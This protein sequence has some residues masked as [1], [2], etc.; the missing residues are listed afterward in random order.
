MC[1]HD[2]P[3]RLQLALQVGCAVPI[4]DHGI[5]RRSTCERWRDGPIQ[6]LENVA[7]RRFVLTKLLGPTRRTGLEE[8][9]AGSGTGGQHQPCGQRDCPG[10]IRLVR[11]AQHIVFSTSLQISP[12]ARRIRRLRRLLRLEKLR[13]RF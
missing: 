7:C 3:G 10:A 8:R 6:R 13:R 11:R 2:V 4:D 9:R 12:N 1:F 5:V